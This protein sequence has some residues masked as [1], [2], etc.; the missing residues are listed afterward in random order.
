MMYLKSRWGL[1]VF[2]S[3]IRF[4]FEIRMVESK[5][6]RLYCFSGH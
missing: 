5:P 1:E 3:E 6:D 4:T 2:E